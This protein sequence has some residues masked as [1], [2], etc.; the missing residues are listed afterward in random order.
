MLTSRNSKR[1]MFS[2]RERIVWLVFLAPLF[3]AS[4]VPQDRVSQAWEVLS[5][6]TA[7]TSGET[8]AA[9]L[10]SL[11][12]V[13]KNAKA[14]QMAIS[15]LKDKKSEVQVA[16]VM[17][18]GTIG[19]DAGRNEIRKLMP[20]SDSE[21]VFAIAGALYKL[22]DPMAYEIFYAALTK[23]RKSGQ[24]LVESQLKLLQN[25]KALAKL[26]FEQGIGFIPFAGLGYGAFK[27][28]TKDDESPVR[29]AAAL[30]LATDKDPKS[31]TA[32]ANAAGDEKWVVRAAAI[33]AITNRGDPALLKAVIPRLED[34]VETVR[35][36]A[37][38]CII[39]LS[40]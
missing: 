28:F 8:R 36:D 4:A 20:S 35:F 32:L 7:S 23:Q 21:L 19:S 11:E 9:A 1:R 12:L 25:P 26:G 38:A 40:R 5:A 27:T 16:A 24:G 37:A 3:A 13:G 30:R 18:L 39:R 15:A 31:A 22:N 17:S 6:G 10:R 34:K 2:V 33:A 29:A 14:E